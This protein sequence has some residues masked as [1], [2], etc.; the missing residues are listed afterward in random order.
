MDNR[1]RN[2]QRYNAVR[3]AR[4]EAMIEFLKDLDF[5]CTELCQLGIEDGYRLEREVNSYRAMQIARYFGVNVSKGKLIQFSKPKDHQYDFTATQLMDYISQH[6]D[7]LMNY[8]E[9][10]VQPAIR[11]ARKKYPTDK[12]LENMK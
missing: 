9:W 3:S 7:E 1:R 4:V 8:W 11:E 10:F 12:E 6:N 5:G 2:M